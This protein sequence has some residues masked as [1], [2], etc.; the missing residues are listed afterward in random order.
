MTAGDP[1]SDHILALVAPSNHAPI[2][3]KRMACV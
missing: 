1:E 2:G 3:I